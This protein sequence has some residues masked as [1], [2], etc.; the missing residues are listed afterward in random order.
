MTIVYLYQHGGGDVDLIPI[1]I[2]WL[3]TIYYSADA[4]NE[5]VMSYTCHV[6]YTVMTKTFGWSMNPYYMYG[7]HPYYIYGIH[8]YYMYGIHPYYMYGIHP[9]YMYST[10]LKGVPG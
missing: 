7:I 2:Y 9:Y 8:P 10:G 4:I 6:R 3:L 5:T 1:C